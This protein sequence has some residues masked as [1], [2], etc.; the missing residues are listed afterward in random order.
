MF[1]IFPRKFHGKAVRS[2]ALW[3]TANKISEITFFFQDPTPKGT[4]TSDSC[5]WL[6]IQIPRLS[7][8]WVCPQIVLTSHPNPRLTLHLACILSLE[9]KTRR[10]HG[11]SHWKWKN[12]PNNWNPLSILEEIFWHAPEAIHCSLTCEQFWR[13]QGR[14][15][16]DVDHPAFLPPVTASPIL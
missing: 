16:F 2:K 5:V 13:G 4:L 15:L 10:K 9:I 12:S 8:N 6:I 1:Q 3:L 14:P 11:F 7:N